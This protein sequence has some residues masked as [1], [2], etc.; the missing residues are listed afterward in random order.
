[1]PTLY[2]L[3]ADTLSFVLHRSH[4]SLSSPLITLIESRVESQCRGAVFFRSLWGFPHQRNDQSVGP[5][6]MEPSSPCPE[7]RNDSIG[8]TE[9]RQKR[10]VRDL[11]YPS[12]HNEC[13]PIQKSY[14]S[15]AP[16]VNFSEKLMKCSFGQVL[17]VN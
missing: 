10:R 5:F 7:E 9:M 13:T 3:H 14:F 11:L 6:P 4:P 17:L 16:L 8:Q 2:I 12:F 1:M 15:G